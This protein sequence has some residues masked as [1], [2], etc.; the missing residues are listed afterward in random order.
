MADVATMQRTTELMLHFCADKQ[1]K[2][3]NVAST[4][5]CSS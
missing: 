2:G 1:S 3:E 4:R 5:I